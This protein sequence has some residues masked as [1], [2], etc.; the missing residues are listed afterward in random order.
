[1]WS[2]HKKT[3]LLLGIVCALLLV[4]LSAF[5]VVGLLIPY[6]NAKNSMNPDGMLTVLTNEDGTLRVEWPEGSNASGYKLQI[7]ESDGTALHSDSTTECFGI[8]PALPAD[9]ELVVRVT[10]V[11]DYD[12]K[13]REGMEALEAVI[14]TPS[15]KIRDLHWNPDEER[16]TVDIDF[17]MSEGDLCRVYMA[18]GDEAPVLVEELREG[19]LQ[20]RFGEG[21]KYAVPTHDQPLHFSFQLERAGDKVLCQGGG[22]EGFTLTREHLLGTELA[23]KHTYIGDNTYTFTWNETKGAYYDVRFSEDGGKTWMTMA[24][25]PANR[26]RTY[27]TPSLTAC[28]DYLVSVVAVGGYSAADGGIAAEAEPI[29]I[30]TDEKLLYSTI[31]P[32]MDLTVCG[33]QRARQELGT[34]AA[35][36]AWCLL[37]QEGK[38]FKIRYQGQD[39]YINSDY[40]MINVAEYLGNLCVY[41]ITNSY[42]SIYLVH[43]YGIENVSGTVITGYEDVKVGQ[44]K[45][46]VPL[47]FPTAQKLRN[48]ALSAK[49]Q[50]YKL[51]IYDSY[52]PQDAT[53]SIYDQTFAIMRTAVPAQ[54]FTGKTV[55]DLHLLNGDPYQTVV[56]KEETDEGTVVTTST[57]M[58]Y[59]TLMTNNGQYPLSVFLAPYI[60]RHNYGIALDLTLADADGKELEMQ[61]SMHDLSWYSIT[62]R[63][64]DN[65]NTLYKIMYEAGL[66][67]IYSEWWHFQDNDVYERRALQPLK[68]GVSWECWVADNNGWRYRLKDG[69]FYANC[70]RTIDG[71]SYT[72]DENGYTGIG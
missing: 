29:A 32:L 72:F 61:T 50:G 55:N 33:D 54:T 7:L 28:T 64:N 1:M 68:S 24:H 21:E 45:Y 34:A 44:E 16:D 25:I 62:K 47:L 48:A 5:L 56:E 52:R 35:G 70:T 41:D 11:H 69:S 43:E 30:H 49:E 38:Y 40:C 8:V 10:S 18:V 53:T 14:M 19:K 23:V 58:P 42:S 36:S 9:R 63:N 31:W 67:N 60:S 3:T 17:D 71:Q 15:P 37:G 2:K 57:M 12:G 39:G 6:H 59:I 46:L 65:A 27:T 20:L 13:T 51:K 22:A 4:V 66:R 26:D